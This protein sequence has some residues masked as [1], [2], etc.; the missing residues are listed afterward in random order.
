VNLNPYC[1]NLN[2]NN[3]PLFK[4]G[5]NVSMFK[6]V[7][8]RGNV[9]LH[10][11][12]DL[13]NFLDSLGIKISFFETFGLLANSKEYIHTDSLSGD[14]VKL[15]YIF[16][17]KNSK[18]NWYSVKPNLNKTSSITS[19]GTQYLKYDIEEVEL[20]Y[21]Q[22]VN[23]PSIVQVGIPHSITNPD[24]W[25]ICI[26]LIIIDSNHKRISMSVAQKIFKNYIILDT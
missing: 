25:R 4:E 17:G 20:V 15:N 24:T 2:F 1:T 7:Q 16:G 23:F 13:I 6:S 18:M 5:V 14:Y 10:L 19:I 8:T 11:H 3:I 9:D 12:P 22:S 21:S 26:S